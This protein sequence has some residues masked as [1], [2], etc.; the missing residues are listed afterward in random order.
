M[1]ERGIEDS[2]HEA[3]LVSGG[4]FDGIG[5]ADRGFSDF[6]EPDHEEFMVSGFQI[7]GFPAD[8]C[9]ERGLDWLTKAA[10]SE[11]D[12]GI[13]VAERWFCGIGVAERGLA[14]SGVG[15]VLRHDGSGGAGGGGGCGGVPFVKL[16]FVAC[17]RGLAGTGGGG[18]F[19]GAGRGGGRP[20]CWTITN[21][22]PW[23]LQ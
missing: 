5:V 14:T 10:G 9:V 12:V 1:T 4:R 18:G 19:A 7:G 16:R 8:S 23:A 2:A 17:D 3:L 6:E 13:G 20:F 21:C 22:W 15:V 11:F